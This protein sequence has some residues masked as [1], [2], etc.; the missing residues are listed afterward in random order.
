MANSKY[1]KQAQK[2]IAELKKALASIPLMRVEARI[3]RKQ[4]KKIM[5]KNLSL[6]ELEEVLVDDE[7]QLERIENFES[8]LND[9]LAYWEEELQKLEEEEDDK[10]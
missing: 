6:D 9:G 5:G 4:V 10:E 8:K 1:K 3:D 7:D 2:N